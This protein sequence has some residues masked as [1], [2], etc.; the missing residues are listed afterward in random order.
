MMGGLQSSLPELA[1]SV[2]QPWAWA[3]IHAGKDVENRGP[4]MVRHLQQKTGRRAIHAAKG[5]TRDEYDSVGEF[6]AR[7]GV[8]V[9]PPHELLRG[10]IIGSVTVDRIVTTMQSRWFMGPRGLVL[11]DPAPCDFIPALGALGYFKWTPADSASVAPLAKWMLPP[12]T[13][14]SSTSIEGEKI[15]HG[16]EQ[17]DMLE[18]LV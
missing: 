7:L 17:L 2:R 1:L 13:L 4:M 18:R 5:M 15:K 16:V 11:S 10:G 12:G 14:I 3:I 9:P 6:M 8:T